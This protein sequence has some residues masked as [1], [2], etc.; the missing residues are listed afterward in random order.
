MVEGHD[1]IVAVFNMTPEPRHA[2]RMG[3]PRSGEWHEILNSDAMD[4][5][6]GNIGNSGLVEADGEALHGQ[7]ASAALTLPPLGA[8]LLK[9]GAAH[10]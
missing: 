8:V 2:Y 6:G 3:L 1:P 10:Q 9:P 7:P 4:Y 5:G